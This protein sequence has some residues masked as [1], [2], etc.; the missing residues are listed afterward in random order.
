MANTARILRATVIGPKRF[1][2]ELEVADGRIVTV[3]AMVN[4]DPGFPVMSYDP[5]PERGGLGDPRNL[6]RVVAALWEASGG[7]RTRPSSPSPGSTVDVAIDDRRDRQAINF[8]G[9]TPASPGSGG[10][11][12]A[13][14][15][16][17]ER[18]RAPLRAIRTNVNPFDV[19]LSW[20]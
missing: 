4:D 8:G 1:E 17:A 7:K 5:D 6:N 15:R 20:K 9:W 3:T 19:L 10:R 11:D 12:Q 14:G 16:S 2:I 13:F 18:D